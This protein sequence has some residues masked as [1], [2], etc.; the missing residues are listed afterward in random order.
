[1]TE[2]I[3]RS[4]ML[5]VGGVLLTSLIIIFG[6]L[7]EYFGGIQKN[8]LWAELDM[9]VAG[10][11]AS[12]IEYL[13]TLDTVGD[14]LTWIAADGSVLY[15]GQVDCDTMDNHAEREEVRAALITGEGQSERYSNTLLEKTVYCAKRLSD[16]TVLRISISTAGML[17]L[18]LGM[19]Q[20]MCVV[21]FVAL[22]FALWLAD[23]LAKRIV[24][25][26]N[27]LDLDYPLENQAYDEIAPLLRRISQQNKQINAQRLELQQKKDEF[28]QITNGMQECLALLDNR[29]CVLSMNPAARKLFHADAQIEGRDFLTVERD[30]E[31]SNAIESA[32][33]AGHSEIT[34]TRGGR[35]FR[36]NISR[37]EGRTGYGGVVLLAFDVTE[38]IE[39]EQMR[40]EFTAN[41][42]HELKTPLTVILGSSEML[43]NGMVQVEDV[44]RFIDHIHSEAAR[45]LTLIEDII[46]LSQLDEGVELQTETVALDKIAKEVTEQLKEKATQSKIELTLQAEKCLLHGVPQLFYEIIYNLIE[47]AIKYNV[48]NGSVCVSVSKESI[49]TVCDTGIG[50]PPEHQSRVFE[51]FYRVDK[52][53]SKAAGGTGLGLSIVKH[54]VAYLG[55]E[56]NLQSEVG[57][58]TTVTVRFLQK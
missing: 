21:L 16:G 58:G 55:A 17:T 30:R 41:V 40:R 29:G 22:I 23:R 34:L 37:I 43:Q 7:Y 42:S 44:P 5:A 27:T 45:L 36:L 13:N 11:E 38:Q 6:C 50:I 33:Q 10:V 18:V 1:M 46:R 19:L 14:R 56:L 32:T 4:I 31:V 28:A 53:R 9:A 24:E 26:L 52:S 35:V 15:D 51:R 47:N 20:P 57:K 12:G 48:A 2:K 54:A 39:A 25:P 3:F 8:Q 49:L